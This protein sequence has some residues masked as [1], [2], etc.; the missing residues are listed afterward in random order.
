[1]SPQTKLG[2]L[3]VGMVWGW[4]PCGF[5]YS[6]LIFAAL[7]GGTLQGAAMMLCFGMGTLPALLGAGILGSTLRLHGFR[8]LDGLTGWVVLLFGVWTMIGP[9]THHH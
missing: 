8:R 6:V 4:L 9:L 5:V 1:M 2:S 7:Q 3:L